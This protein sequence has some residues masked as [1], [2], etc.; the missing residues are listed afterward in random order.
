MAAVPPLKRPDDPTVVD[1]TPE[2]TRYGDTIIVEQPGGDI[3]VT[4]GDEPEPREA[5]QD[6]SDNLVKSIDPRELS[7]AAQDV[8]EWV[9][10]DERSRAPWLRRYRKGLVTAG[11]I[12]DGHDSGA[13]VNA[14]VLKG[15]ED[16]DHPLLLEA[17]V[18]FQARA[19]AEL[20]PPEGPVK[21]QVLG[22]TTDALIEQSE[23][24][25]DFMNYQ[26]TVQDKSYFWDM[27]KL[28]L[29]LP[30]A[31]SCFKKNY[32]DPLTQI[33]RSVLVKAEDVL[34][35]YTASSLFDT[36]RLTHR[37]PVSHNDLLR[38]QRIGYYSDTELPEASE[39]TVDDAR[40]IADDA[41]DREV[42]Y[43]EGDAEHQFY[44]CEC[45]YRFPSLDGEDDVGK[46][47]IITVDKDTQQVMRVVRNYK[48][49][50]NFVQKKQN[51]VHYKY[52]PGLGFYGFGL[53][54]AM[55]G[56]SAGATALVRAIITTGAYA[57]MPGG[58]KSKTGKFGKGD[59]IIEPGT[60]KDVDMDYEELSKAIWSP[61][62][63]DPSQALIGMLTHMTE[64][65]QRFA[66]TTEAMVGEASVN[67]PVGSTM[68]MIEQGSKVYTA[69]HFRAH[70]SQGEEFEIRFRLNS[71]NLP[72]SYPYL[73]G[74]ATREIMR[75]DFSE[76]VAV[77]PVSDPKI[78]SNTQRIAQ[79]QTTLGLAQTAPG[80]Y[81]LYEVHRRMLR[82]IRAPD[83]DKLL[84][85]PNNVPHADP[86]SEGSY[87]LVGKPIRAHY[88]E[89]HQ[90]HLIVHQDQMMRL[91]GMPPEMGQ[92]IGAALQTHMAEHMAMM[93]R[94]DMAN[95]L[96]IQLPPI[97]LAGKQREE[98]AVELDNQIAMMAGQQILAMRQAE[99]AQQ[100]AAMEQEAMAQQQAEGEQQQAAAQ[101]EAEVQAQQADQEQQLAQQK[102]QQEQQMKDQALQADLDRDLM[103]QAATYLQKQGAHDI[104]PGAL[105]DTVKELGKTFDE[106]LTM[107]RTAQ[108]QGQGVGPF[109]ETE[110]AIR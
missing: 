43:A 50:D 84:P 56:L 35:P 57:S 2:P 17:C 21:G 51:W 92:M 1:L 45:C 55:G 105:V 75:T 13:T 41:D 76:R 71:E 81:D 96:G 74:N 47:Y 11:L 109:P 38:Y 97:D 108:A 66:S 22:L 4:F 8:L 80:M 87:L 28:L 69:I 49:D 18:Q 54:H 98:Q 24:V 16:I 106:A 77:R 103:K 79:A 32:W 15:I 7:A 63:R 30:L 67:G 94:L 104:P 40:S 29:I 70:Q 42:V 31:G 62:F 10:A 46:P 73:V 36:P 37:L 89:D 14:S 3:E 20:Y 102:F 72:D 101:Q 9:D 61:T 39:P 88:D 34:V 83:I 86:V 95:Q 26:I 23:R 6:P 52:L 64:V 78:F 19:L 99:A 58:F 33:P 27:D 5:P 93:Y 100:Q 48:E 53:I 59:L 68:A 82:A 90:S 44:E 25:A 65:G 85:D 107:I 91:Q 12:D 60:F 110:R